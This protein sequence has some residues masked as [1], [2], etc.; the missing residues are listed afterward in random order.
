[1]KELKVTGTIHN[2]ALPNINGH[3]HT[4]LSNSSDKIDID[5]NHIDDNITPGIVN[6]S[7]LTLV[8]TLIKPGIEAIIE[9]TIKSINNAKDTSFLSYSKCTQ[10]ICEL[11]YCNPYLGL[12]D[13][14]SLKE[15]LIEAGYVVCL[16]SNK[17]SNTGIGYKS[18]SYHLVIAIP[19]LKELRG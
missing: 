12:I 17:I 8:D 14:I 15:K 3:Y 18:V 6:H 9:E 7:T 4:I 19:N 1:M 5:N 13:M 2:T 10:D 11:E 16:F